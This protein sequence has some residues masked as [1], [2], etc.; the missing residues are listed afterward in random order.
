MFKKNDLRVVRTRRLLKDAMMGLL[1]S[2]KFETIK[3]KDITTQANINRAT[4][5]YHYKDKYDL[6]YTILDDELNSLIKMEFDIKTKEDYKTKPLIGILYMLQYFEKNALFYNNAFE[7][8]G[9]E[10]LSIYFKKRLTDLILLWIEKLEVSDNTLV[11]I[12]FFTKTYS[13]V[14]TIVVIDWLKSEVREPPEVLYYHLKMMIENTF[15]ECL[16]V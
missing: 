2:V 3:V 11:P 9:Y 6:L 14:F 10:A 1:R 8:E 15:F 13:A 16:G 4:F 12:D 7:T 5:Y